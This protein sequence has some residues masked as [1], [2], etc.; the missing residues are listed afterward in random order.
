MLLLDTSAYAP[1]VQ[2]C[3]GCAAPKF[4]TTTKP[5]ACTHPVC[6]QRMTGPNRKSSV[7]LHPSLAGPSKGRFSV[8]RLCY[9][10][11]ST[12]RKSSGQLHG[13]E[14]SCFALTRCMKAALQASVAHSRHSVLPVPVGLSSKAFSDCTQHSTHHSVSPCMP[15]ISE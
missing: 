2:L 11:L 13:A 15:C 4:S 5:P 6:S 12:P 10:N 7:G 8:V 14:L 1:H 3:Q 9:C